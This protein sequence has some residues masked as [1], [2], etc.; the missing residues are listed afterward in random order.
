MHHESVCTEPCLV[1][2][3]V[4]S[5]Q[6]L[7][8]PTSPV[9][10][11]RRVLL[12]L[13]GFTLLLLGW[14]TWNAIISVPAI[15]LIS[16]VLSFLG[17][18]VVVLACV[19]RDTVTLGRLEWA[20][21]LVSI[22]AAITLSATTLYFSPAYGTDEIAF[23]QYAAQL[24]THGVNPY[25]H[26]L[27]PALD[28]FHVPIKYATYTLDGRV[29][30]E[31]AYP[32]LA[33]LFTVPLLLVGIVSQAAI[34]VNVA[35]LIVTLVVGFVVFP[36]AWRM[37]IVV[38]C[39][40]IPILYSFTIGGV[41]DV[42]Y[43]PFLMIAAAGWDRYH[44]RLGWRMFLAP[45]M[46][47]LAC[48]VKQ[49]PWFIA[50]FLVTGIFM[51]ARAEGSRKKG[52]VACA[53]FVLVAALT[54]FVVNLPFIVWNPG[55]WVRGVFLPLTQHSIP[56]G[57]GLVDLSIYY[58]LGGGRVDLYTDGAMFLLIGIWVLYVAYYRHL[59]FA[60]FVLPTL[61]LYF[62]TRSLDG[63]FTSLTVA[64]LVGAFTLQEYRGRNLRRWRWFLPASFVP[65]VAVVGLALASP[66]PLAI[67]ITSFRT[68]GQ[69]ATVQQLQVVVR[70]TL[71]RP[72]TPHFATNSSGQ[73]T[74]FWN[75][76]RGP[77]ILAPRAAALYTLIAPNMDSMPPVTTAFQ[78]QVVTP[79]PAS[80]SSSPIIIPNQ[81]I[82]YLSPGFVDE[83]VHIGGKVRF[84]VQ[85][86]DHYGADVH[87]GGV[88]VSLGQI[89][90]SQDALIAGESTIN[91]G[92][93]G[94]TPVGAQTDANG[95]AHF[96]VTDSNL[97]G[98][99]IYYEAWIAESGTYPYG[100]SDIVI[101]NWVK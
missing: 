6:P 20:V 91:D 81:T 80:I 47:G 15:G 93:V 53:R 35:F 28:Q 18:L 96:T 3:A 52:A 46:F 29:S 92:N 41:N 97:Q 75:V 59:R 95:R 61:F 72:L 66:A 38:L 50:P 69:V 34:I 23:V 83:P 86:R 24:V 74:T 76:A 60:T 12:A 57:Q 5:L 48:A 17:V 87:R 99:P 77:A 22:A 98:E 27:A 90:Y 85:L 84:D 89:I 68:N 43:F 1:A 67:R 65:G 73:M 11:V 101:V 13:S 88:P 30:S 32:D 16:M 4:A 70:N 55:S 21:L 64:G 9:L 14:L 54:F 7:S 19:C 37:L 45:A 42:I 8:L 100:Y 2:Q 39:L 79:S 56:Y 58:H 62:A 26:D 78:V 71:N 36:R 44:T 49:L 33:F 94:Q 31:L 10:S 25:G 82:A 51:E 40:G 63:Y